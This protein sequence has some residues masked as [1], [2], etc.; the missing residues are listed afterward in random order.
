MSGVPLT[1][2]D[3]G[4]SSRGKGS[5]GRGSG[6]ARGC[7][8]IPAGLCVSGGVA[9]GDQVHR[10]PPGDLPQV[11]LMAHQLHVLPALA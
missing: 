10:K 8:L 7:C 9:A 6:A 2:I 1:P 3:L 11:Q 5:P 4:I